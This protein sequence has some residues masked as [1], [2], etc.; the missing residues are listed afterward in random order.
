[1]TKEEFLALPCLNGTMTGEELQLLVQMACDLTTR[2]DVAIA[3]DESLL[4]V[5]NWRHGYDLPI[6]PLRLDDY[7]AKL[8]A[9]VK[10]LP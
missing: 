1:M 8:V 2:S 6:L 3:L 7:R 10:S 4:A 9:L 5:E